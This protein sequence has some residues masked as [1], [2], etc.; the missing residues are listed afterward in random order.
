MMLIGFALMF[1]TSCD[2]NST[3]ESAHI[4][5]LGALLNLSAGNNVN[6][7]NSKVA[8]EL[9]VKNLNIYAK[10]AGQDISF[11]CTFADTR[12]DTSEAKIQLNEMYKKGIKMFVGGPYS[13][14]ELQAI[15]PFVKQNSIAL[16]NSN[17]TAIG[18][19]SAGSHIYRIITD[20]NFQAKALVRTI[21]TQDVKTVIP[22]VRNDIGNSLFSETWGPFIIYQ[23]VLL[24]L[25]FS[26]YFLSGLLVKNAGIKVNYTRK[27]NHFALFFL[28]YI[29]EMLLVYSRSQT[30]KFLGLIISVSMLAVFSQTIRERSGILR[31]MFLSFDRPEDRPHTMRWLVT[32]YIAAIIVI[33]PISMYLGS[34]NMAGLIFIPVLING[35]GDGL[36]EPVGIRFGRNKYKARAL[37]S[38]KIYERSIEGSLCVFIAGI[39]SI[40]IFRGM[41][42]PT[43]F[44]LAMLTVPAISTLA[45]A[46]S[47]HTWDTPF[48]YATN[49][50]LLIGIVS[51]I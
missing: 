16:I 49:G 51:F 21:K 30:T 3:N 18:L 38:D 33:I 35:F 34:I 42:T 9:A 12:M 50:L 22:I 25:L 7:L 6:A 36:A 41:F 1:I 4:V 28:P 48:I 20:D 45:E 39:I 14:S 11:T 19:N 47:P 43:Q 24:S 31:T 44:I 10:T 46:F 13:S 40:F 37:F 8:I 23:G 29:L 27:I 5:N 2:D 17:S 26:I 15:A 32:Q